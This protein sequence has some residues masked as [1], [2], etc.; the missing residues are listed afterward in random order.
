MWRL[1]AR[2]VNTGLL[3]FVEVIKDGTGGANELNGAIDATFDADGEHLYVTSVTDDSVTVFSRDDT[4]GQLTFLQ[5]LVDGSGGVDGLDGAIALEFNTLDELLYVA[6]FND[7]ALAIFSRDAS[8]GLLTFEHV[9]VNGAGGVVGLNGSHG[10]DLS[11]DSRHIYAGAFSDDSVVAFAIA[12]QTH[13]VTLAEA[14][15]ATGLDFGNHSLLPQNLPPVLDP[16]GN[17]APADEGTLVTFTATAVDPNAADQL[18]FS[19]D[20]GAPAGAAIDSVSGL[21][22]WTPTEADGPGVFP[23][24]VR[25]TDDGSPALDDFET[26]Q[27]TVT[28][29]NQAP[30]LDPIGNPSAS[31]VGQSISFT[32]TASDPD[33]PANGLTFTLDA[34]APAGAAIDP[35]TGNFE[36]TP[37]A[38]QGAGTYFVT[39]RVTDDGLPA[40]DDFE[41]LTI[42]V[43][44]PGDVDGDGDVDF[45][46]FLGLQIGFGTTSGAA[47]SD[48]DLDGDGDVDFDDFLIL[49]INFGADSLSAFDATDSSSSDRAT[50][51][52]PSAPIAASR[53][54]LAAAAVDQVHDDEPGDEPFGEIL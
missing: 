7:D 2:D 47:R 23:I 43:L 10:V 49:Q 51:G 13:A 24:T 18:S 46:D 16:I 8:T 1:S 52:G 54:S 4:T 37:S 21:F 31:D 12:P 15:I 45:D 25:V 41:D 36:W 9:E 33:V 6:G 19:L 5:A 38:G 40:L 27:I 29:V 34:G 20:P 42:V 14:E 53:R 3:T 39:V 50:N 26:V 35:Q 30:V 11:P 32:A 44:Q 48:G 22:T 28:E 17:P